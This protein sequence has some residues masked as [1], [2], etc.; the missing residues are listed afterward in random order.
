MI[1]N[2]TV[3]GNI[4]KIP[5]MSLANINVNT[6]TLENGI[7][8]IERKAFD[9]ATIKHLKFGDTI[10]KIYKST[11]DQDDNGTFSNVTKID[12]LEI[13][14][15]LQNCSDLHELFFYGKEKKFDRFVNLK[16]TS[17]IDSLDKSI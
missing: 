4:E 15:G 5:S 7:K 8:E 17:S 16:L 9:K 1:S 2:I 11:N 3:K 12:T 6:L 10:E 13:G 14:K